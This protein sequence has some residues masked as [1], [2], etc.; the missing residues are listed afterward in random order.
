MS[1][2]KSVLVDDMEHCVE[3]GNDMINIHH[4]YPGIANRKIADADGYV[5]PLCR[6]CHTGCHGIH[7]NK[8]LDLKWRQIAQ[9]HYEQ[10]HTRREFIKRYGMS[11]L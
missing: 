10:A 8:K 5:I 11:Y 7:F 9:G 6:K 3:C 1:R 2:A 4:I